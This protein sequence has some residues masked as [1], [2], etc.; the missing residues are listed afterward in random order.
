M[1]TLTTILLTLLVLGGCATVS[2]YSEEEKNTFLLNA[3]AEGWTVPYSRELLTYKDGK[4]TKRLLAFKKLDSDK[5]KLK[6]DGQIVMQNFGAD[7]SFL[8]NCII[9]KRD[10]DFDYMP[11]FAMFF[12]SIHDASLINELEN[13]CFSIHGKPKIDKKLPSYNSE[14]LY[15]KEITA[16]C[17]SNQQVRERQLERHRNKC[18]EYG[19]ED[20]S[21]NMNLCVMRQDQL[22]IAM[23]EMTEEKIYSKSNS[24]SASSNINSN[25]L[26]NL[27]A[28]ISGAGVPRTN[29]PKTPITTYPNSFSS[30][31]TVPSNQVCPI[32]STPITKQEI[33]G[34]NRI[35]YYQ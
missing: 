27:G 34:A 12:W 29:T 13:A 16:S 33:R 19:I 5:I 2:S 23:L 4:K 24:Q 8:I 11:G 3:Q 14:K 6:A 28:A 17:L 18:R 20:T 30:S 22:A 35:C 7:S 32:L 1:K 9:G 15:P 21:E 31:L 10:C 26:I 25:A